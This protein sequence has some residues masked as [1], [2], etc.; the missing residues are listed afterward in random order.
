MRNARPVTVRA[1]P[2]SQR[3]HRAVA[4]AGNPGVLSVATSRFCRM[5]GPFAE[6]FIEARRPD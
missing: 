4:V 3:F 5:G 1:Q 6:V 2:G